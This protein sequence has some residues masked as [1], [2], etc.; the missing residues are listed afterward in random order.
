VTV[1]LPKTCY[2]F[3]LYFAKTTVSVSVF[4]SIKM[5]ISSF[6]HFFVIISTALLKC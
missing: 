5:P 3:G 6:D 2:G 4:V 1:S